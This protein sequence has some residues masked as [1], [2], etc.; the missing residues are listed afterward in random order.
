VPLPTIFKN[1][2]ELPVITAPMFL[3]SG[4]E[5]IIAACKSGVAASFPAPNS[6]TIEE[7]D[8]WLEQIT[9]EIALFRKNNKNAKVAPFALN[10]IVHPANGRLNAE[11]DLVEKYRL[12]FVITS[13]GNPKHAVDRLHDIGTT[14]FHDVISIKHAHKAIAAGVDGLILVCCGSGGHTGSLN[15]FAFVAQVRE[16]WQGPL[17]VGGSVNNGETVRAIEV[18]GA[19]MAYMGSRFIATKESMADQRY[20]DTLKDC[21]AD[22]VITTNK[23]T[24]INAN[25]LR[26]S[27]VEAG[28]DPDDFDQ[29]DVTGS[30][31][32][33]W[34]TIL[35]AGHGVGNINDIPTVAELITRMKKEYEEAL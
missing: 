13:V 33:P 10:L 3:V 32:I 8:Q 7:L 17:V 19:D 29:Q 12:P 25:F 14:V 26:P 6:R 15:P 18:I 28:L 35:S 34:K 5:L 22:D 9:T 24:G 21:S 23:F 16:F 30:K 31:V 1:K 4:P 2:L 11:L 20:K 27:M